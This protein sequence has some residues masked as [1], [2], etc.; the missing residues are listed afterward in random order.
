MIAIGI[1]LRQGPVFVT[2]AMARIMSQEGAFR[3]YLSAIL[4]DWLCEAMFYLVVFFEGLT[5]VT[6]LSPSTLAYDARTTAHIGMPIVMIVTAGE[7][8]APYSPDFI[9]LLC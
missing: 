3:Y 8:D 6:M 2:A 9:R 4:M 5:P 1:A 7:D